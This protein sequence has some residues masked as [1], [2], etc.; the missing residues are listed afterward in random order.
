MMKTN[1]YEK[2]DVYL[3]SENGYVCAVLEETFLGREWHFCL[4]ISFDT[5]EV[6]KVKMYMRRSDRE[7]YL[8][9]AWQAE[10]R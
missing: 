8:G 3:S 2:G 10:E 4:C 5:G 1:Y 9:N 7:K 6:S